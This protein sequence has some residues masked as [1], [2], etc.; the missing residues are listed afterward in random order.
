MAGV[1]KKYVAVV[2]I[3]FEGLKPPVRVEQGEVIPDKVSEKE[4]KDLLESG[5][6]EEGK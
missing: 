6:I 5:S 1:K 4:I 2:G 3:D